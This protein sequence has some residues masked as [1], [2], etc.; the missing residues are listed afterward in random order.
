MWFPGIT[1]WPIQAIGP[2]R[3]LEAFLYH[4][5]LLLSPVERRRE[6]V[7][8]YERAIP[9]RRVAGLPMNDAYFLPE[10]RADVQVAPIDQSDRE[11]VERILALDQWPDPAPPSKPVRT[12][13]RE[14]V[15]AHWHGAPATDDLYAR[16]PRDPRRA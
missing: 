6:K 15:D 16:C 13:T 8:R 9:G 1:H 3:Y 10:D 4:T 5:D 2:H 7:R 12:A 11:T 14:E